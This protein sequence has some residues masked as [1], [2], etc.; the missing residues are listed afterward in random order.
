M[1]DMEFW[2]KTD[3]SYSVAGDDHEIELQVYIDAECERSRTLV[4]SFQVDSME[5]IESARIPLSPGK[6]HV[7]FLQTV[8]IVKPLVWRPRGSSGQ[9]LF[10]HFSVVFHEHGTPCHTIEKRAG[11]RFVEPRQRGKM[12]RINGEALPL[13]G[14]EPDFTL[15]EE[16]LSA[17][18]SG[19]FVR[20]AD[21]DPELEMKLDRCCVSGLVAALELTGK[22]GLEKLNPRPGICFYTAGSGS[23]GEKLYRREKQNALFPFFSHDELNLWLKNS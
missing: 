4:A 10:Y 16:A 11:I 15:E 8:R 20:L 19:N 18:L 5:M 7:P 3:F 1:A 21:T 12:F 6:N 23:P 17:A 2:D 14:C 9:P 13:T 22:T